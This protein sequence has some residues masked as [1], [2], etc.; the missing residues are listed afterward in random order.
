[1]KKINYVKNYIEK[2]GIIAY[3]LV[4]YTN[5]T[6]CAYSAQPIQL[7]VLVDGIPVP[8]FGTTK[9]YCLQTLVG[10]KLDHDNINGLMKNGLLPFAGDWEQPHMAAP[11]DHNGITRL[12]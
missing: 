4:Q 8:I 6:C 2:E 3:Y 7:G 9:Y 12:H 10:K 1:M 5:C 11:Y